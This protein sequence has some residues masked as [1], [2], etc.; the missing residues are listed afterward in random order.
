MCSSAAL[1]DSWGLP[2]KEHWSENQQVVLKVSYPQNKQLSLWKKTDDGLKQL[3]KRGYIHRVWPPHRAYVTDDGKYVVLRDT[4][5]S[6]GDG[7]VIVILGPEGQILGSYTLNDFLPVQD[8]LAAKQSVSSLWWDENAWFSLLHDDRQFALVTQ[9][10]TVRCFDLPTGKLLDL[11]K[12]QHSEIVGL[13]K[14]DAMKWVKSQEPLERIQGITLLGALGLADAVPIAKQ[15]FQDR[16]PT[17]NIGSS[18]KP[19]A[20]IYGV[21]KAAGLALVRLLGA[22]AFPIIEQELNTANWY[23]QEQLL[24][25]V[26]KLDMQAYHLVEVPDAPE[27]LAFWKRLAQ[28]SSD[29]VRGR[30]LFHVL[31]RDDGEYVRAHPELIEHD[32]EHLRR[33]VIEV[34]GHMN[35]A[36]A[37][38]LL[39][40]ALDDPAKHNRHLALKYLIAHNPKDLKQ[41]LL[42]LQQDEAAGIRLLANVGLAQAGVETAVSEL[43]Q[44]IEGWSQNSEPKRKSWELSQQI[45]LV[46]GLI[47]DLKVMD[48][49]DDLQEIRPHLIPE[50][51]TLITGA[52]AGLGDAD[53]LTKLHAVMESEEVAIRAAALKMCGHLDDQKSNQVVNQTAASA[54]DVLILVAQQ[55]RQ[56]TRQRRQRSLAN[57]RSSAS[58]VGQK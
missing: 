1:A 37:V 54:K 9:Q 49:Q 10:G 47:I 58:P 23:M 43:S 33:S 57:T 31:L 39:R 15:L 35:S 55:V 26:E 8:M 36:A 12:Q 48:F 34:L 45:E 27:I 7:Q 21:Q 20:E 42:P 4:H 25:V 24:E 44:V 17:G 11:N 41:A 50:H 53:E 46:C 19:A 22:D 30:A 18:G 2:R 56:E 29:T 13:V 14:Q 28:N 32:G 3:W 40:K 16:T 38:P 51:Q 6:L 5:H 52:L